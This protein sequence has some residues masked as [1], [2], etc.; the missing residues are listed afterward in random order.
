MSSASAAFVRSPRDVA[1]T[2][3][4]AANLSM[5]LLLLLLLLLL[6]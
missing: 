5:L 2:L 4:A 3:V 6:R 1:G